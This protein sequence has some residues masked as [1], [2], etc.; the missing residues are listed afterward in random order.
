M[1][2]L[3]DK[4][5]NFAKIG[6]PISGIPKHTLIGRP[7]DGAEYELWLFAEGNFASV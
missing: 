6:A 3:S 2:T 4:A 5:S 1:R 7:W